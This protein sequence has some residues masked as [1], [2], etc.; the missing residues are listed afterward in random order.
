MGPHASRIWF[1]MTFITILLCK[2]LFHFNFA[3]IKIFS[4]TVPNWIY[5][6]AASNGRRLLLWWC[7]QLPSLRPPL[8]IRTLRI[9]DHKIRMVDDAWHRYAPMD[10]SNGACLCWFILIGHFMLIHMALALF[11]GP[12]IL[13]WMAAV[14][15]LPLLVLRSSVIYC[16]ATKQRSGRNE[17][18]HPTIFVIWTLMLVGRIINVQSVFC[19][20][21]SS[22]S[23][24]YL[25][26]II[27]GFVAIVR[28]IAE[29]FPTNVSRQNPTWSKKVGTNPGT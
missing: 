22:S 8:S 6:C 11:C 19:K 12:T 16:F 21:N 14:S 2:Q 28:Y 5:E 20:F 15:W 10:M 25:L 17:N 3:P 24:N 7:V 1:I 23:P 18:A 4:N 13:V 27:V 26:L 29:Y 9:Y